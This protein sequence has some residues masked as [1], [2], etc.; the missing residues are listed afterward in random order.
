MNASARQIQQALESVARLRLHHAQNLPFLQALS[1]VKRFQAQR[2][3][4]TYA[5]LLQNPRYQT[6]ARFF[7]VELY[8]E[9]DYS[10][11][12]QQFGRIAETISTIFPQSVVNTAANLAEVHAL[13]EQLD[14][15]MAGQWLASLHEHPA[16][17]AADRYILCWRATGEWAVRQRQ[18]A[19]VLQLGNSLD[20]LT[21]LPGLRLM[22]KMMRGPAALAGLKE[23]QQFLE[24]GFDAFAAMRGSQAFLA[25]IEERENALMQMLFFGTLEVCKSTLNKLQA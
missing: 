15:Q 21:R 3:Q 14:S 22:L 10:Q 7:L 23:L 8:S 12:D 24:S 5:D 18:L 19:M 16:L 20:N 4:A 13:T 2:F 9:K 11:R 1:S 17:D 6:A 25:L